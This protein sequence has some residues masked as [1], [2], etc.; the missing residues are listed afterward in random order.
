MLPFVASPTVSIGGHE[1]SVFG[2]LVVLGLSVGVAV[3]LERAKTNRLDRGLELDLIWHA[4]IVGFFVSHVFDVLAYH[5]RRALEDP[6]ELL[7]FW[8][9]MS[10]FGGM[11]GGL[12][13]MAVFFA[14]TRERIDVRTR[15][16]YVDTIAFGFPFAWVFGRLACTLVFDH[17]GGITTFPLATS[18]LTEEARV[19][20][21]GVYER[22]GRL[23]TLPLHDDL[24]HYGLHNLGF[25]E[26]LYTTFVIVPAFVLLARRPRAPG[27]FVVAFFL[28]YAPI[29]FVMDFAR[30]NDARYFGLTPGQYAAV[31]VFAGAL[32]LVRRL[33]ART[34]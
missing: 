21:A 14:R 26:F 8:G 34:A 15:L 24:V 7:R 28:V 6:V 12:L 1:I 20:A 17:P 18:L 5:P 23:D 31:L 22:A 19:F 9:T 29:R 11:I 4:V 33:A 2:P 27:F 32:L 3:A 10:S 30:M 13:G 25:Y 16:A